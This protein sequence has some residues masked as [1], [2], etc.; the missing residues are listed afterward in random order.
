M[1]R[2]VIASCSV[3][4]HGRGE[5]DLP[6]AVRAILIKADGAVSVHSDI[7]NKPLNYM[8]AGNTLTITR[9]GR[10]Q[11]WTF[12]TKKETITVRIHRLISDTAFPLDGAEP[13]LERRGTEHQLQAWIAANPSC[14]GRGWE[15]LAREY[16]TGAGAVDILAKD[17]NGQ[18]VAVEVKRTAMLPSVDQAHR[19]VEAL[20]LSG[21]YGVV[22]G[23]IAAV[24]VRPNTRAQADR[25]GI[26]W[27]EL[28]QIW[29]ND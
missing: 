9:K 26:S 18:I 14:L 13:G 25:R 21:E 10:Q 24:D 11:I 12:A 6:R 1:V 3:T 4:Y 15:V 8:G 29:R 7:G 17:P 28:P 27:I 22:R 20:N 19:Y 2:V 23:L 5:T 16:P